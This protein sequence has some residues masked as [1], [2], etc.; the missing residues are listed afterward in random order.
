MILHLYAEQD[1]IM[2][3]GAAWTDYVVPPGEEWEIVALGGGASGASC[4]VQLRWSTDGGETWS[5]PFGGAE[6]RIQ[7]LHLPGGPIVFPQPLV[8]PGAMQEAP[9]DHVLRLTHKNYGTA[10]AEVSS[11]LNGRRNI[12]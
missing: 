5:N 12:S 11:F 2:P 9:H 1:A 6:E 7:V 3:G 10:P 8:F 4:E